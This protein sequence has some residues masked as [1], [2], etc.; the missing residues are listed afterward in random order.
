MSNLELLRYAPRPLSSDDSDED[1]DDIFDKD[2]DSD[3]SDDVPPMES[4]DP[5]VRRQ[6]WL[7]KPKEDKELEKEEKEKETVITIVPKKK[8]KDIIIK[9]RI[10][11]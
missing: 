5:M 1:S 4:T 11:L 7:K 6:F 3:D 8:T 9:R 2:S 10:L